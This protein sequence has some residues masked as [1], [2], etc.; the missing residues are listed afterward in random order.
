M[1]FRSGTT[2]V[3][4]TVE[5]SSS[6]LLLPEQKMTGRFG[7]SKVGY[8]TTSLQRFG[9]AQQRTEKSHYITRWRMEPRPADREAYL[10]GELVEPARPIVFYIDRST[11]H[12]WRPYIK[13]GIEEW[14]E[15]FEQAGFKNA[16]VAREITD[17]MI[18]D[19]DDVNYSVLTYAAS[20]KKNAMG[21]SLL[22][23]RDR[24][25]VV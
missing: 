18:V 20:E 2:T 24:K 25:S 8:F 12:R 7:S 23:L 17:S 14:Q 4:V 21:P 10:R 1:L 9:D 13:Q 6:L 11:P 19:M 5:V 3:H 16:I 22:E 15:A